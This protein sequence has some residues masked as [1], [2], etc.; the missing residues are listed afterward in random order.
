M[1]KRPS[2]VA[3][4]SLSFR[5]FEVRADSINTEDR[6]I[7]VQITTETPVPMPDYERWDMIPEVLLASGGEFPSTRQVPLLDSHQ[8]GSTD[9]QLGSVRGIG[10]NA[11][12]LE[13]RAMFSS[14]AE[15]P[16]T[17][18]REGHLRDVSAGY[19]VID[20]V[21]V[22]KNQKQTIAGREFT[23]PVNVVTKWKLREVSITPIG[24]DEQAKMRGFDA[25]RF[26]REDF[27]MKAELR[28]LCVER[29]MPNELDD[30]KAQEWVVENLRGAPKAPNTP[31]IV[32]DR[33]NPKPPANRSEGTGLSAEE[34][35][36]MFQKMIDERDQ[37]RA[38]FIADADGLCD[39][40]DM[41]E[42]KVNVRNLADLA[43][44]RKH[45]TDKKAERAAQAP[46]F[47]A[48]RV[49]A[50][51][52]QVE[53]HRS[54][55]SSALVHRAL[56][57]TGVRSESVERAFPAAQRDKHADQ[58]RHASLL[59]I[60]GECLRMD[61]I[62]TRGL[63]REQIAQAAIVGPHKLGLRASTQP[64]YHTTGSFSVITAD[65]MNK[66]MMVGYTEIEPT[67]RKCFRQAAS[68]PDFKTIHRIR[69]GALPNMPI[70][71][72][73]QDPEK[74][75]FK[76]AQETYAVEARAQEV[77]FS[78]KL[79]VNDDMDAL[80]RLPFM[81]GAS[82]SRTVNAVAWAQI[83]GNPTMTDSVALFSAASG[84]RKRSNLTTGTG[85]PSVAT[86][87]TLTNLMRQMRGENTPEGNE[88]ADILNL[89]PRYIVGPSAL[90]T[91]I[92][93]LVLSIYDPAQ[94]NSI[95]FNPAQ[96]LTPIIEPLLDAAS[97]TAW[98]LF[99]DTSQIDT[100]EVTFL[101]GQETP[102]TSDW[103]DERQMSRNFVFVQTCAA[104]A[105]NHR[106]MQKHAGA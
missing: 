63:S 97:T 77:N 53:K 88:S 45:I 74:A 68:V 101:Q 36:A 57:N 50:G 12:G 37:K 43:A 29:G 52:A 54:A 27:S 80:S 62:D 87:Q 15:T 32:D 28:A 7:G 46:L 25:Q 17:K 1:R 23:G 9:T 100:V 65:A 73:N 70:W 2:A 76:D 69:M 86:R 83:T 21:H 72:D 8:R 78:W 14:V 51:P 31:P 30:D 35:R 48:P 13:G 41:P 75:S 19:Q 5:Q 44:V 38:A 91:T 16:W 84:A 81:V 66:S 99:A 3:P 61:G 59:D 58:F 82:A 90:E 47:G 94:T 67:W 71:V 64:A 96:T 93:Q 56:V 20:S 105:M 79:L 33:T 85:A 39:L 92:N 106:G 60:A 26:S 89:V 4:D 40:A 103:V 34:A 42:E 95:T 11:Q 98:Y 22:P 6:S 10:K 24:A 102:I 49:E 104:K 55:V 18:I